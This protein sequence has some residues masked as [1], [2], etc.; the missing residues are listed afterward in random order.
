MY[1]CTYVCSETLTLRSQIFVFS[2]VLCTFCM[3]QAKCPQEQCF[4]GFTPYLGD[5]KK[6]LNRGFTLCVCMCMRMYHSVMGMCMCP[7]AHTHA[8]VHTYTHTQNICWE[9]KWRTMC[10]M[11]KTQ[12]M[13]GKTS[14]HRFSGGWK[15]K[16]IHTGKQ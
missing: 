11:R 2:M 6:N 3:L 13:Y 4:L 16:T 8:C 10:N 5:H 15:T 12:N 14:M 1:V 7:H 9:F